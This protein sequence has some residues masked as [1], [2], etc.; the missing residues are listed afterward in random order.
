MKWLAGLR[1]KRAPREE[2]DRA[3][4]RLDNVT[5]DDVKVDELSRRAEQ[6]IRENHLAPAIIR[7]LRLR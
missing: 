3:Q 2:L 5:D 1:P 6:L 4:E 7:A